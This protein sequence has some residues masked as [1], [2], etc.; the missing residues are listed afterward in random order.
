MQDVSN[1]DGNESILPYRYQVERAIAPDV[2]VGL[3]GKRVLELEEFATYGISVK[4][5]SNIDAP[6]VRFQ[7]GLPALGTN[8]LLGI[9][10]TP[11]NTNLRGNPSNSLTDMP[12]ASLTADLN[13]NGDILST[14]YIYDFPTGGYI[15]QNLNFQVDPNILTKFPGIN[16]EVTY[17]NVNLPVPD[18]NK[19]DLN[20]TAPTPRRRVMFSMSVQGL[21]G[22]LIQLVG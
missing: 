10:Y 8:S 21:M 2:T 7:Y 1:P 11:S 17:Y 4:S 6:Y 9:P 16:D 19:F 15:G 22:R 12:W 5:I 14:G 13:T 20:A 3:T 18:F